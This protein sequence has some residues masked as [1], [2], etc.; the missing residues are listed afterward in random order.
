MSSTSSYINLPQSMDSETVTT[1]TID[2]NQPSYNNNN[3]NNS[4]ANSININDSSYNNHINSYP[5]TP[6]HSTLGRSL[7]HTEDK[8]ISEYNNDNR[9][10]ESQSI[11][12]FETD[13]DEQEYLHTRNKCPVKTTV[14]AVL[15]LVI[16]VTCTILGIVHFI[17]GI[18]TSF[19]FFL[20]G[21]ILIIPGGYQ[22]YQLFQAWRR[23]PGYS[24][25]NMILND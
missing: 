24:F 19:A 3:N 10:L 25:D 5:L 12:T 4:V 16:G 8:L 14:V 2:P 22:C 20:I 6:E 9:I 21:A 11:H 18:G 15:L 17:T 13:A 23:K 1:V 7:T